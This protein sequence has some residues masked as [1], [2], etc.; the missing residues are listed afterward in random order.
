MI[1]GLN[2]VLF[3]WSSVDIDNGQAAD[4]PSVRQGWMKAPVK[5]GEFLFRSQRL[6]YGPSAGIDILEIV[7]GRL[8]VILIP[9]R[10]MSLWKAFVD[11]W[12]IGWQSPVR[13]PI[14]PSL[15]RMDEPSGLGWLDG[16]DELVVRCGLQSNGAPE[17]DEHGR[18][19]YPLHGR[20]GNLPA[21][22]LKI[23]V[24][25][26]NQSLH[27]QGSVSETRFL[28]QNLELQTNYTFNLN[29]LAIGCQDIVTNRSA[30]PSSMQLLYH[31][32]IGQPILEGGGQAH[33]PFTEL[34]PRDNH[35]ADGMDH[36]NTY[37][38]PTAGYAEQVYF[39]KPIADDK[40]WSEALLHDRDQSKGVAVAFDTRNLPYFSLWKN[41]ASTEDGYVTGLEPATNFPNPRSFEESQGR[42]VALAP[43]ESR[44]FGWSLEPLDGPTA[45]KRKLEQIQRLQASQPS[46]TIH[47]QPK[48]A[49]SKVNDG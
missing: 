8:R 43:N 9:S 6:V 44:T 4:E 30:K 13:G 21:H 28:I 49:W 25:P 5:N 29:S 3:H 38:G 24:D 35:A 22:S 17:F 26:E 48:P 45:I 41:T 42:V 1:E 15:V 14:H 2:Q 34:A 23:A 39:A 46:P 11:D 19:K 36:W 47:R 33:L 10:G 20:I 40:G 18:L 37:L 32:N 7:A 27:V 16:F 12:E 31:I